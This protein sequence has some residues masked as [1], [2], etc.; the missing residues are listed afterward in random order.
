MKRCCNR[1]IQ[2]G[3][4]RC[5]PLLAHQF[6]CCRAFYLMHKT[7][8]TIT[9]LGFG[10]E[11]KGATVD[12]LCHTYTDIDLVVR[13]NGGG[14]AT[15]NVV[16]PN[17]MHHTFAQW[18]AGSFVG[19][20]RTLLSRFMM[21]NPSTLM[22]EADVLKFIGIQIKNRMFVDDR[23]LITTPFHML[24]NRARE[25]ARGVAQHGTTGMGI[26]ETVMDFL[27]NPDDVMVVDDLRGH[28]T[29]IRAQLGATADRLQPELRR[30]GAE[31]EFARVDMEALVDSYEAFAALANIRNEDEVKTLM[32]KSRGIVIEGAQGVL[33]DQYVGFHPHTTWSSTTTRNP[34]TLLYEN[35]LMR[36]RVAMLG[37]TRT[38]HTR[39]GAGP[40]PTE[41]RSTGWRFRAKEPHN[42]DEGHAGQFRRGW[43]DFTL[44]KYAVA[45]CH[46]LDG[47]VVSHLDAAPDMY[48][49]V[50]PNLHGKSAEDNVIRQQGLTRLAYKPVVHGFDRFPEDPAE[51]IAEELGVELFMTSRGPTHK[52]REIVMR[53]AIP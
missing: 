22:V 19:R 28:R 21:V 10:D 1:L 38:Y 30:L 40:F 15:H 11:T 25:Q 53:E 14:Q 27:A 34:F 2:H 31:L 43:L 12:K 26:S 42:D 20:T 51:F 3:G 16:R 9:G 29:S 44:L 49:S 4:S 13:S 8:F 48:L 6:D 24:L 18:G 17:G 46:R 45:K 5:L 37:V 35:D 23:C 7:I 32:Q 52:D 36:E 47:L 33:L 39:H 50:N 41:L